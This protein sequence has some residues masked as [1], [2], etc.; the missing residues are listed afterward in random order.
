[1][2]AR[3]GRPPVASD[4]SGPGNR[5]TLPACLA[6]AIFTGL[7]GC[8]STPKNSISDTGPLNTT[9]LFSGRQIPLSAGIFETAAAP[10][11]AATERFSV[12]VPP[13]YGDL[14]G[15]GGQDAA[16]ILAHSP[17][18]SGTFYYVAAAMDEGGRY[19][20]SNAFLLGDRIVPEAVLIEGRQVI[21]SYL[22][23]QLSEPMAAPPTVEKRLR[24][25]LVDGELS[26]ASVIGDENSGPKTPASLASIA[27]RKWTLVHLRIE[28]KELAP[29][30]DAAPTLAVNQEGRVSGLATINRYFGQMV[31]EADG[32]LAWLGPLGATMM[33]GPEEQMEQ[34]MSFLKALQ[35]SD[36][37]FFRDGRL[38]L[39]NE[40]GSV[41]LEFM[42]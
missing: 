9:Y 42:P 29:A 27:D 30:A 31:V 34:E 28:G 3:E 4:V 14:D 11:S 26:V 16:L 17:G 7:A 12:S 40:A 19:G 33:A 25:T 22:D 41:I 38:I 6:L 23:R 24:L 20:G 21:V 37:A 1:M 36:R 13:V 32:R 10:G 18:G 35:R 39:E 8:V 15:R 2:P 5:M